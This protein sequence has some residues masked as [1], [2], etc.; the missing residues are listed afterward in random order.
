MNKVCKIFIFL[1]CV[2]DQY[3]K[4][5][6]M[7]FKCH[8]FT[9]MG[10]IKLAFLILA[11]PNC[12]FFSLSLSIPFTQHG[13]IKANK[14]PGDGD[15]IVFKVWKYRDVLPVLNYVWNTKIEY[16]YPYH[17]IS[18]LSSAAEEETVSKVVQIW[19]REMDPRYHQLQWDLGQTPFIPEVSAETGKINK[20]RHL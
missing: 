4:D 2:W 20:S 16:F 13:C 15:L 3:A 10:N 9:L 6:R 17:L 1:L 8:I 12:V 19:V 14:D 5:K 7:E 11:A 18:V